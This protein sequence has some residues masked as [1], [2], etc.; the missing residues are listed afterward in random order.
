MEK[1]G[2]IKIVSGNAKEKKESKPIEKKEGKIKVGFQDEDQFD[3]IKRIGW[4]NI[5]KINK[6]N[7]LVI[8]AGAIGNEV[9]KDLALSGFQ[10]I[11]IVDMDHVVKSN[12]SR[13]LFFREEDVKNKIYKVEAVKKRVSEFSKKVKI[14]AV[15]KKLEELPEKFYKKFDIIF[16]CVDNIMA[17]MKI[18]G[19]AYHYNIPYIDGGTH[20]MLG[21]VQVMIPPSSPCIECNLN[22]SHFKHIEELFT[23]SGRED[24]TV[25]EPKEP[26]E[27]TTTAVISAVMVREGMKIISDKKDLI[28]KD[29]F[30]YDGNTAKVEM[31]ELHINK[32]CLN[33]GQ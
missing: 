27:I 28:M 15:P 30:Y 12:L 31:F 11:T 4:I 22:V 24:T 19:I 6:A 8:G 23:C 16:G 7:V 26:A 32:N 2:K 17:R 10:K 14:E 29:L 3:R 1:S 18:N 33:H 25:F 13:C 21:K 5:P 9:I 20:G